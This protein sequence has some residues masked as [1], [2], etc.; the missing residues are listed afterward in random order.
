VDTTC[1]E[2]QPRNQHL[3]LAEMRLRSKDPTY[4]VQQ[5]G[6]QQDAFVKD[7]R[8]S[9]MKGSEIKNDRSSILLLVFLYIL[10]GIP[11]GLAGSMP[12]VLQNTGISYKQQAVFSL[13]FWPFS[14]KLLWA[15]IVDS[16]YIKSLGRR[17]TWLV[18]TQYLIGI[19]MLILS[20]NVG[21][22][23][24]PEA[25][26]V[27]LL[28]ASFFAL[29]FL[30]ATQDIAVDGWA[31]TMLSKP[32]R[33]YASTCNTVGQTAGY[34]IGNVVFLAL[35]SPDF[36]NEYLRSIPSS[37]GVVTL[38]K[39]LWF[40]GIVFLITT[41]LVFIFKKE[42]NS[43]DEDGE[44][45]IVET[46]SILLKI[47]K[48]P[49]VIQL[50]IILLTVKIGFAA[51]D[52]VTGLKLI[53]AGVAKETLAMLAVPLVP[54]QIFLPLI[55]SRYTAGPRPLDAYKMAIPFRLLFGVI[56][57]LLVNWT[58][59]VREPGAD[60]F[61]IYYYITI[62]SA[63]AVHQVSLYTMFVSGMAFHAKISDPLIGGTYMTLLNTVSNLGGVWPSS[64]SL[65]AIDG[66]TWKT[67]KGV[68]GDLSCNSA[69][70]KK[71]CTDSGGSCAISIDGY[72]IET[73]I[74]V[75]LG[76]IWLLWK[77][78]TLVNLQNLDENAWKVAGDQK[79][80]KR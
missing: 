13:V 27:S 48:L 54:I 66:L 7:G 67:C 1:D 70:E 76:I 46:Y 42:K 23:L 55:I 50:V 24:N 58:H 43:I 11:L 49:A 31:L 25:P 64:L 59:H 45:N 37:T 53:E 68:V 9:D 5:N 74:C 73:G 35:N 12:M 56:F 21:K 52:A 75:F 8:D 41:T 80:V 16:V 71:F 14:L 3:I 60:S 26:Q 10:Q 69:A 51:T 32:N 40:W 34:F 17:K 22:Y 57:A 28:T 62:L 36:C 79:R 19:F 30:A 61:P 4:E 15:P 20:M 38:P 44:L 65:W 78:R 39:F 63:Y 77:R 6:L 33:G 2:T 18:P 29:N 47:V 72:Y